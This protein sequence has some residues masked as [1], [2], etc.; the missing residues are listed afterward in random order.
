MRD[1]NQ[2][3]PTSDWLVLTGINDPADLPDDVRKI[4]GRLLSRKGLVLQGVSFVAQVR[5]A[6]TAESP[7]YPE[8]L[9]A[10]DGPRPESGIVVQATG[11]WAAA[12]S[13]FGISGTVLTVR[14]AERAEFSEPNR[15]LSS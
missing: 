13:R 8:W 6:R 7:D 14:T 15:A 12:S 9:V 4:A 3:P 2:H 1:P 10:L 11:R 5:D